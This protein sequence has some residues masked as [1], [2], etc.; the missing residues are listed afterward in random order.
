MPGRQVVVCDLLA[1]ALDDLHHVVSSLLD[2]VVQLDLEE[3]L[4][5]LEVLSNALLHSLSLGLPNADSTLEILVEVSLHSSGLLL[6]EL[7]VSSGCLRVV[8][9]DTGE[10]VDTTL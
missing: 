10:L 3:S 9:D 4:G 5:V 8:A 6:D 7:T 2:L 1:L